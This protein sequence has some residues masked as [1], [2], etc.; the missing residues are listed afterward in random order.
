MMGF[1]FVQ[2][3]K[4]YTENTIPSVGNNKYYLNSTL[5][6]SSSSVALTD[7][8]ADPFNYSIFVAAL[9]G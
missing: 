7:N 8:F 4:I 5:W 1:E 9:S 3:S 2:F 6:S